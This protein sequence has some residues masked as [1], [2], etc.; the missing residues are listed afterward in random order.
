MLRCSC[1]TVASY[2][3]FETFCGSC[4]VNASFGVLCARQRLINKHTGT[5]KQTVSDI[6]VLIRLGDKFGVHSNISYRHRCL[7]LSSNVPKKSY[8]STETLLPLT[9]YRE[10]QCTRHKAGSRSG[11]GGQIR[12]GEQVID[13]H[14]LKVVHPHCKAPQKAAARPFRNS[15]A[16]RAWTLMRR[17]MR[18]EFRKGTRHAIWFSGSRLLGAV[19]RRCWV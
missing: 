18:N 5:V 6:S 15:F 10:G 3:G 9:V 1:S 14:V 16:Q 11:Q 19:D 4:G 2:L 13:T 8:L 12:A 17:S 7:I